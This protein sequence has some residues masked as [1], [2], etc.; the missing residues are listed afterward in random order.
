MI[1]LRI[2]GS[3]R[4]GR[5]SASRRQPA[6]RAPDRAAIARWLNRLLL[7]TGFAIVL[8]IG[9]RAWDAL[10][11]MPVGR[12][13]VAGTLDAPRQHALQLAVQQALDGGFVAADLSRVRE[14]ME[15]LP[16]VYS[17]S[18]RRRWPDTL[19][20]RVVEQLPI[21]RWGDSG[22]LNHEGLVFAASGG[23]AW[24]ELPIIHGPAGSERRLMQHYQRLH[25]L[26]AVAEL[27]VARL[28]QDSLG[29]LHAELQ[30]GLRI[31]LGNENFLLRVQRFLDLYRNDLV[32]RTE[33][34]ASVDLR[35]AKGAAVTF[36]EPPQL[37]AVDKE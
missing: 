34:V 30:S 25:D 5:A 3:P 27:S 13:A 24:S 14:A 31:N 8:L 37:A 36:H 17:A 15:A 33:Q 23:E 2:A 19:D 32:Q 29:Q 11:S 18:V 4:R 35:Y 1:A 22:F 6:R 10:A 26:L 7:A 9:Q 12:I 20:I 16:W 21:A 28:E